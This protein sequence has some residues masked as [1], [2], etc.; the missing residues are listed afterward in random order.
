MVQLSVK[1]LK[2]KMDRNESFTLL[3][4]RELYERDICK[5]APDQHIPMNQIP[6]RLGEI[7]KDKDLI[8]YCRSGGRSANV[9]GFLEAQGF[10]N[11]YNLAGGILAWSDDIDPTLQKY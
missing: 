6:D 11:V 8:V 1:A 7:P 2:Q 10:T 3:D 9:C 4:V 5:L